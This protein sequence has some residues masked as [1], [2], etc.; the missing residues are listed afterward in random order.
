MSTSASKLSIALHR[1]HSSRTC[2]RLPGYS[3]PKCTLPQ[4]ASI[5][6][7]IPAFSRLPMILHTLL[8]TLTL[9][10]YGKLAVPDVKISGFL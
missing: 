3:S 1:V 4:S 2:M 10:T 9:V 7:V 6:L 5:S 8:H